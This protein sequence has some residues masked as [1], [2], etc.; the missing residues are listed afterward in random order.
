[1]NMMRKEKYKVHFIGYPKIYKVRV[2]H[3][4]KFSKFGRLYAIENLEDRDKVHYFFKDKTNEIFIKKNDVKNKIEL[5]SSRY[6][7]ELYD[8]KIIRDFMRKKQGLD[9]TH[10]LLMVVIGIN[11]YLLMK[12]NE[13]LNLA[14]V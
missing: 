5:V 14:G 2:D 12:L 13:L 11:L 8:N 7:R 3:E 10:I 4:G 1:M 9:L 6:Y